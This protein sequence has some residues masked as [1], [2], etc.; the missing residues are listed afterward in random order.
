MEKFSGVMSGR[1]ESHIIKEEGAVT[2]MSAVYVQ[3]LFMN[4]RSL[5]V[6]LI[7]TKFTK[8]LKVLEILVERGEWILSRLFEDSKGL[9]QEKAFGVWLCL[10][11]QWEC[12]VVDDYIQVDESNQPLFTFHAGINSFI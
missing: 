11:F 2:K 10:N 12:F 4:E 7:K 9:L 8:V 5:E 1:D 6:D 3:G